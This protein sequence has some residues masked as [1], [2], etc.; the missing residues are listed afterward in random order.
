MNRV[1]ECK[2]RSGETTTLYLD[3]RDEA[4]VLA[5]KKKQ[6]SSTLQPESSRSTAQNLLIGDKEAKINVTAQ[7]DEHNHAPH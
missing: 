5:H 2:T 1:L 6:E 4:H 7:T 3:S